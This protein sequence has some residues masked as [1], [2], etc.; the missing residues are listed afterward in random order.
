MRRCYPIRDYNAILEP[1]LVD[2]AVGLVTIFLV[3]VLM[4]V[5]CWPEGSGFFDAGDDVESFGF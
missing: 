3:V 2:V 1:F 4:V 5:F